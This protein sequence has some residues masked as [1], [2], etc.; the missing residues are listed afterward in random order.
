VR[1]AALEWGVSG[2]WWAY[3]VGALLS[4]V[5]AVG[6]FRRGTWTGGVVETEQPTESTP[7]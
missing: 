7:Q 4:F 1:I 6:W 3:A 5:V 2:L